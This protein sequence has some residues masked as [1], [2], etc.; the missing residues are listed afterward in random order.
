MMPWTTLRQDRVGV[1]KPRIIPGLL[2]W[3]LQ[4]SSYQ[5]TGWG[6][7]VL[8][9]YRKRAGKTGRRDTSASHISRDVN[10]VSLT[11]PL[12]FLPVNAWPVGGV[13]NHRFM[14]T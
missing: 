11:L 9:A 1:K 6:R 13:Y 4:L 2:L 8:Q 3:L 10:Y 12:A 14:I 7:Q 5:G